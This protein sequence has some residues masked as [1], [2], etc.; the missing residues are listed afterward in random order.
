MDLYREELVV[1]KEGVAW[2]E[3]EGNGKDGDGKGEGVERERK[4]VEFKGRK[5][6]GAFEW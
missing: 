2:R 4:D 5:M 1:W 6:P 3:Q